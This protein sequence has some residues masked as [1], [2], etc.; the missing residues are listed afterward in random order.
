MTR[1]EMINKLW[2]MISTKDI[3]TIKKAGSICGDWNSEHDEQEIFMCFDYDN[4]IIGLEDDC[5]YIYE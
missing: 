5:V 3:P 1:E 2:D 4:G